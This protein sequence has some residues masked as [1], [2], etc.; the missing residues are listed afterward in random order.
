MKILKPKHQNNANE[1]LISKYLEAIELRD[2]IE[3]EGFINKGDVS[4]YNKLSDRKRKIAAQIEEKYPEIKDDFYKLLFHP[5]ESV[6]TSVAHS[7]LEIMNYEEEQ[8]IEALKH[9][10][11]IAENGEGTNQL[12]HE[13]WLKNWYETH[14]E[15][16]NLINAKKTY[17]EYYWG[18]TIDDGND[19]LSKIER[20]NLNVDRLAAF[21][22]I[23][24]FFRWG[25][26]HGL[27]NE[28]LF[29][30][31]SNLNEIMMSQSVDLREI[32]S[33]KDYFDGKIRRLHFNE[34][35]RK[36]LDEFYAF[37]TKGYAYCVDRYAEKYWG[38]EKYNSIEFQNEA[39]LFV[40]FDEEYYKGLSKYVEQAYKTFCIEQD[41]LGRKMVSLFAVCKPFKEID[42]WEK[43]CEFCASFE[44]TCG[45]EFTHVAYDVSSLNSSGIRTKKRGLK[46]LSSAIK[47]ED[48][49][50]CIGFYLLPKDYKQAAFDYKMHMSLSH[51][52]GVSTYCEIT[53][54]KELLGNIEYKKWVEALSGFLDII[55]VEVNIIPHYEVFNYNTNSILMKSDTY[56]EPYIVNK[57][58][59]R[60]NIM[61]NT[62][63]EIENIKKALAKPAIIF[64]T[65]G[66]RPTK[67]LL[68]SWI[69]RIGW[70]DTDEDLPVDCNGN[71][72]VPLM[73]LF[74][75]ELPYVPKPIK[76][77][78]LIEV[79]VSEATIDECELEDEDY[80]VRTYNSLEGLE[81]CEWQADCIKA[82]PITA[83]PIDEDFPMWDSRD[84]PEEIRTRILE[85]EKRGELEYFEDIANSGECFHKIGGYPSFI[86]SGIGVEGYEF[87]FQIVSDDKANFY[88]GDAGNIYFFYSEAENSW[89]AYG[90]FY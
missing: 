86:Q 61:G 74:T 57:L 69:G 47:N 21:N 45:M 15:H 62:R 11:Y 82:F 83:K 24:I 19:H 27:L 65:G 70:K 68:E 43:W 72:M 71:T 26:E 80:V 66:K 30:A 25:F 7:I 6:R 87:V 64:E 16:L 31:I 38:Q 22:H 48:E 32:I 52:G 44:K 75:K 8:N 1:N 81:A 2:K 79:F 34:K 46:K 76:D 20:L 33:D 78:E 40:P 85:M 51:Y 3:E 67:E 89:K 39:Y 58:Y 50:E 41:A 37:Y 84:I 53:V 55:E 56:C 28:K 10:I 35:G 42:I 13:I 29:E 23:A 73:M 5:R 17:A 18:K 88:Y 12:G 9:I 36:F 49:I 60:K 90:D 14:P 63:Q 54:E 4:K 59:K 77:I